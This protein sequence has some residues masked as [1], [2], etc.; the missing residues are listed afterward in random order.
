[1]IGSFIKSMIIMKIDSHIHFWSYNPQHFPWISEDMAPLKRNFPPGEG[2]R[3]MRKAG[4]EGCIVMQA[5]PQQEEND[6]LMQ[7][8][9]SDTR[10]KGVVGWADLAV[11]GCLELIAGYGHRCK[12]VGIRDQYLFI[13]GSYPLE[14]WPENVSEG[15]R[16]LE[17]L[18][19]V[20][21]L[22]AD[23]EHLPAATDL[24]SRFPQQR[25]VL[26]HMGNPPIGEGSLSPW[27]DR[28]K[29]I[30][31]LPNICCKISGMVRCAAWKRWK[32]EDFRP[33]LDT[34]FEAFGSQRLMFGSDWPVCL[35][36]ASYGQVLQIAT[37]YI[38]QFPAEDQSA[39]LGGNA[40]RWYRLV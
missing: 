3:L 39:V 19:L 27:A 23:V 24:V 38:R 30:A 7:L 31:E 40:I 29:L 6:Y 32:P 36:S 18:S 1:M 11:P 35:I 22:L 4:I 37:D 33:Y 9:E 10:V 13:G 16:V 8:A 25:F 5:R 15:I 2:H 14:S 21:E 34:V 12:L 20:C 28:I 26:N 17:A